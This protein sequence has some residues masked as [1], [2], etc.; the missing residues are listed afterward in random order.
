MEMY[1]HF[2][3]WGRFIRGRDDPGQKWHRYMQDSFHRTPHCVLSHRHHIHVIGVGQ[4]D[5]R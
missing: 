4:T 5:S 3:G 2:L 1:G